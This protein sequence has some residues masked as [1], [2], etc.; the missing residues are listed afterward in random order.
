MVERPLAGSAEVMAASCAR[1]VNAGR[2]A[3]VAQEADKSG[4]DR[5]F[6]LRDHAVVIANA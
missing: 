5:G 2:G 6:K 1:G 4:P 3:A